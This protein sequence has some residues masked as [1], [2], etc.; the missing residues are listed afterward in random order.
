MAKKKFKEEDQWKG[1]SNPLLGFPSEDGSF[2]FVLTL[3]GHNTL[4]LGFSTEAAALTF[5]KDKGFDNFTLEE[6]K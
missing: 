1:F 3:H 5:V 2:G 4:T 6:L